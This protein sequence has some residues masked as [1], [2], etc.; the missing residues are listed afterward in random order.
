MRLPFFLYALS[1]VLL[2]PVA[3]AETPDLKP[4]LWVYTHNTEIEGPMSIAPQT[5]ENKQCVTQADLDKGLDVLEIPKNCKLTRV[6]IQPAR[7]DYAAICDMQGMQTRF[8]G[9]ATFHGERMQG[10]MNSEMDTPL[11]KMIM[12]MDYEAHRQGDC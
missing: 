8:S 1:T 6:D 7:A 9:Y 2:A 12:K 3:S 10:Q 11:G 4:G 5:S